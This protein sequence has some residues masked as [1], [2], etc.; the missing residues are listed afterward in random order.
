MP[1]TIQE[2][3]DRIIEI[4]AGEQDGLRHGEIVR[5]ISN[6][7]PG[8]PEGTIYGAIHTLPTERAGSVYKPT[9][10]VYQ[11]TRFR[12]WVTSTTVA[13]AASGQTAE[14]AESLSSSSEPEAQE[15]AIYEPFADFLVNGLEECSKAIPLGGNGFGAKWGTPDVI[16]VLRARE[17]HIY[18]APMEVVSAEVKTDQSQLV[19]AFGQACAYT[20]FSHRVYLVVPSSARK[21]DLDRLTSLC[22][23]FGI[24]LVTFDDSSSPPVFTPILRASRHEPDAYYVNEVLP[25]VETR[26]FH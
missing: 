7:D 3:Q 16:G 26:L 1:R 20:L 9:R 6:W 11:H 13:P 17:S 25:K 22:Q 21:E 10:G 24:G 14:T 19:V 2:I 4:L 8:V 18:K 5:R 15:Q 23:I 12:V